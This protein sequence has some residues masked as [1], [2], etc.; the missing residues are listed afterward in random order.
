MDLQRDVSLS[1]AI[2]RLRTLDLNIQHGFS[3]GAGGGSDS[4]W[5]HQHLMPEAE[6]LLVEAQD[7]HKASLEKFKQQHYQLDYS[8][9]AAGREDGT[10]RF[11]N[12]APTGGALSSHA[13]NTIEVPLRSIDSLAAERKWDGPFFIK[14][15]THGVEED[16]LEGA[17]AT[18][19]RSA[20]LMIEA[21]NFKLNFVDQK[22]MRFFELCIYLE[23]RGF[24]FVDMCEPLFRPNS[25]TFWQMQMFFIR[26]DHAV[27]RS[28]SYK[29]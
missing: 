11:A 16:I 5:I 20:L 14:L 4:A 23:E 27:F 29:G 19:Q 9:C 6:M 7:V 18:L 17:H 25:L 21:Y 12:S 26:A 22:N 13:E 1:G 10:A 2:K 8:L 3:V 15:D 24:R 28:N